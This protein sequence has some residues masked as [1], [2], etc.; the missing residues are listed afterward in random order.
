MAKNINEKAVKQEKAKE[1]KLGKNLETMFRTVS[2]NHMSLSGMADN[3]AH[4]LLNINSII[5]SIVLSVLAHKLI[6]QHYLILPTVLL[7]SVCLVSIVFAILT[8][9]PKIGKGVFTPEQIRNKEVN[10][11]FFGNF[12]QMNLETYQWGID[13]MGRDQD[14]M[15]K[16]LTTDV[17]F[18]GRALA[19]KY[20]Y[21]NIGYRVFMFGLIASVL[22]FIG[23]FLFAYEAHQLI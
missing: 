3:K 19:K 9:R 17:Y 4:I 13:E 20:R 23:S 12:H 8:T 21:L 11:L 22:A 15:Q 5:I 7:L 18:L 16:S 10:L 14:F 6:A 2:R 1:H